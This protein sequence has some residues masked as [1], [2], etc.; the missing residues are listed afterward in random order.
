SE[1][2]NL[3]IK[4]IAFANRGGKNHIITTEIEHPSVLNTCKWLEA[5]GFELTRL[6]PDRT[7]RISPDDLAAALTERTCLVSI[8]LANNETG[9]IQPIPELALLAKESGALFHSDG[10]QAL[11][12]IPVDV[13]ALGV[14]FL[15]LSGHKL[16]GPKGVGGLYIRRGISLEPLIHGGKQEGGLRA[17]TEN[18]PGIA[19]FGTA[20]EIALKNLPAM[21]EV[22]Q[23][24]DTLQ[25]GIA[26]LIPGSVVNGNGTDR[27]PN[28]LNMTLPGM[29]GES[30]VMALDQ[31][32]VAI[33]SGSACR[34]GS[35]KPSHVLLAIGLTEEEAH[36][37]IR[38]SLGTGNSPDE[39]VMALAALS[40][41]VSSSK[42]IVRFVPCR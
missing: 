25:E 26:A 1:S 22:A 17:G 39:I 28:T 21:A 40:E 20:A 10:V 31:R 38:L 14:D 37:S 6:S 7:G 23:M 42:N 36:C 12:K 19:G 33:S 35:P 29:R 2:N 32:G 15:S 11:G 30:V 16:H 24:R 34:S 4:S 18:L 41:V 5:Q 27:L 9:T 13:E 8:M 3:V